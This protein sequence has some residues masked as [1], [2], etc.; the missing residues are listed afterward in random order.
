MQF[1]GNATG[2]FPIVALKSKGLEFIYEI[3]KF[4][5]LFLGKR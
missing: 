3:F 4:F 2:K 1:K 5:D